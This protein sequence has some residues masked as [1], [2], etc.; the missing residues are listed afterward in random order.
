M[1]VSLDTKEGLVAKKELTLYFCMVY[2]SAVY[3]SVC[4]LYSWIYKA[5]FVLALVVYILIL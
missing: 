3:G 2:C 4:V 1:T 5:L